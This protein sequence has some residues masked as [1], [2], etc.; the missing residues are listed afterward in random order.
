[1]NAWVPVSACQVA[2]TDGSGPSIDPATRRRRLRRTTGVLL[3][4]AVRIAMWAGAGVR[5]QRRVAVC[6]AARVLTALG[7]R[8]E[9]V[10]PAVRWP[11]AGVGHL[12]VS[13]HVSWL[14][15][16]ALL[17]AVRA[18]PVAKSEVAT[19]PV[20]GGLARRLGVIFVER[21]RL[22]SVAASVD[23]VA[24]R[25]RRGESVSVHPEGTTTCGVQLER[26][27]PA[28]FQAAVDAGAAI[29]PVAIRYR[30]DGG[31]MTT[32]PGYL[33][34]DTLMRSIA[35]VGAARGLVVEVHLLPAL[36]ATGGDRR[37]LAALA[38]YAV[39]E[40]TETPPPVVAVHPGW[41]RVPVPPIRPAV[42]ASAH[43]IP[44]AA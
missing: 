16:L 17:V 11:R 13:N 33:R 39:A 41:I 43:D 3:A 23:D 32:L 24:G 14:D 4:A 21:G 7:I 9:V 29:C 12:V 27:R 35:R 31:A 2:C 22:R 34:N 6:S 36:D 28:F 42:S 40:V 25:L 37:T 20:V 8:V 38:E 5:T 10:N 18:T 19:W 44:T 1:M 26:F 30:V 15:E